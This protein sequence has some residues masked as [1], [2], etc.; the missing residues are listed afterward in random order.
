MSAETSETAVSRIEALRDEHCYITST[1][2]CCHCGD[3]ECDGIGCIAALDSDD[4]GDYEAIEQLHSL[5]REG[6]AWQAMQRIIEAGEDPFVAWMMADEALAVA[7]NMT[8]TE[9]CEECERAFE[10]QGPCDTV[11][12]ACRV[13]RHIGSVA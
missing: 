2:G 8:V 1:D 9:D 4:D 3:G 13:L 7:N 6:Q 5:L 12:T 10:A 11:C